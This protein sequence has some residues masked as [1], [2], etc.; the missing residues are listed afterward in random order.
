VQTRIIELSAAALVTSAALIASA[1]WVK[2]SSKQALSG[3]SG[4]SGAKQAESSVGEYHALRSFKFWDYDQRACRIEVSQA[5]FNAEHT[6]PVKELKICEPA[7]GEVWKAID[8]GQGRFVSAVQVCTNKGEQNAQ[9]IRGV[10]FWGRTIGLDG[11]V[12]DKGKPASFELPDCHKWHPKKACPKGMIATGLRA[13]YDDAAKGFV[14][15]ELACNGVKT[16]GG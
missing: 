8:L 11:K 10:R 3:V 4:R 13:H 12:I 1:A 15:L 16:Q 14:G 6:T 7:V 2:D 5:S 9:K